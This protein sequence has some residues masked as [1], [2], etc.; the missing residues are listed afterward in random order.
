MPHLIVF[1]SRCAY[2]VG[3]RV[4]VHVRVHVYFVYIHGVSVLACV[5]LPPVCRTTRQCRI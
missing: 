2:C 1:F 3:V 4:G 5:R